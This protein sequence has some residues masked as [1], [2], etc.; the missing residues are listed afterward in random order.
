MLVYWR[1]R[2]NVLYYNN[3]EYSLSF[4]PLHGSATMPKNLTW[5]LGFLQ[6]QS[7]LFRRV[8]I[9]VRM[10]NKERNM[11]FLYFSQPIKRLFFYYLFKKTYSSLFGIY[12]KYAMQNAWNRMLFLCLFLLFLSLTIKF[13]ALRFFISIIHTIYLYYFALIK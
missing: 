2:E 8:Y 1:Y 6:T 10:G 9:M 11:H 5:S 4:L 12:S 13:Y 3:L 7:V